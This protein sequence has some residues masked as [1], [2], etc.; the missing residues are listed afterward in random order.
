L[1]EQDADTQ[2]VDADMQQMRTTSAPAPPVPPG[3]GLVE[4]LIN[5]HRQEKKGFKNSKIS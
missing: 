1:F 2:D 3:C 5:E 4:V